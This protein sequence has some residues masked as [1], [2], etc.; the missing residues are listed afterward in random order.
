L[1]VYELYP[2]TID[3]QCQQLNIQAKEP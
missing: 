1:R 2:Q 3:N